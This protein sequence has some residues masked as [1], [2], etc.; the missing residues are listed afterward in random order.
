MWSQVHAC[1]RRMAAVGKRSNK[2]KA[3]SPEFQEYFGDVE[4]GFKT[5]M[6]IYKYILFCT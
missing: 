4:K 6:H 5:L 1:I 2:R 3:I